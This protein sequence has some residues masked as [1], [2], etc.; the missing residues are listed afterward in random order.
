MSETRTVKVKWADSAVENALATLI[1]W[2]DNEYQTAVDPAS[3][4]GVAQDLSNGWGDFP[5]VLLPAIDAIRHALAA[6]AV[7]VPQ[8]LTRDGVLAEVARIEDAGDTAVVEYLDCFLGRWTPVGKARVWSNPDVPRLNVRVR[9]VPVET[10]TVPLTQLAGRTIK[11]ET[12]AV[13]SPPVWTLINGR[14]EWRWHGRSHVTWRPFP[15]GTLD[16][17]TGLV[18]VVKGEA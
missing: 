3:P 18:T 15:D 12:E 13:T 14:V 9:A 1:A 10:E 4:R 16:L 6:P 17:A 11:G 5:E 2:R 7:D 8:P